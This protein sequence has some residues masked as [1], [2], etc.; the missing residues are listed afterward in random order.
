MGPPQSRSI[1]TQTAAARG[2]CS[3]RSKAPSIGSL[4]PILSPDADTIRSARAIAA[5]LLAAIT[6]GGRPV[7][8]I[9]AASVR[10]A[11][12]WV[13]PKGETG[14]STRLI[15][16]QFGEKSD[17]FGS[18]T[19]AMSWNQGQLRVNRVI[20]CRGSQVCSVP[21]DIP[22]AERAQWLAELSE[23]LNRAH[24]LLR[25]LPLSND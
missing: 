17:D 1:S 7:Y 22:P 21:I 13:V 12:I 11:S 4:A 23:A 9:P 15:M 6:T 25:Q 2:C 10:N 20:K 19:D 16:Q 5:S 14:P 8:P 24:W 3:I 18:I